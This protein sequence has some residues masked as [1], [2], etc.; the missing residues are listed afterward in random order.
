MKRSTC[1]ALILLIVLI[2]PVVSLCG[3]IQHA[4]GQSNVPQDSEPIDIYETS[5]VSGKSKIVGSRDTLGVFSEM[6][7]ITSLKC[8]VDES[9]LIVTASFSE[10]P[11]TIGEKAP[12][13]RTLYAAQYH[14]K[15][16][17]QLK[18]E[19]TDTILFWQSG[20]PGS[21]HYET[22]IKKNQKYILFLMKKGILSPDGQPI[23]DAVG[24]EQ[25]I[26][27]VQAGDKLYSYTDQ[28]FMPSYDGQSADSLMQEIKACVGK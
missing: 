9:E 18:G 22:K 28:G 24:V 19:C 13:D 14:L 15:V 8:L 5:M 17:E 6:E 2:S 4:P 11:Q 26:L 16:E 21:D 23:Y 20:K 3:C 7:I 12:R 27:E 25:G 1:K 10:T